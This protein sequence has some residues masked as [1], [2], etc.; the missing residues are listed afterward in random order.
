MAFLFK[1]HQFESLRNSL[2][3]NEKKLNS[4]LEEF[5]LEYFEIL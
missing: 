3:T 4:I 1:F 2:T 5:F